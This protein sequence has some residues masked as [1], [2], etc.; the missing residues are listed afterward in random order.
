M[1]YVEEKLFRE[2]QK[3]NE[4]IQVR[5]RIIANF[6]GK[7]DS[8]NFAVKMYDELLS[9]ALNTHIES[10]A[11]A[12]GDKYHEIVSCM[13]INKEKEQQE[14]TLTIKLDSC[15]L[16]EFNMP[17]SERV[18]GRAILREEKRN[19]ELFYIYNDARP[20]TKQVIPAAK[21]FFSLYLKFNVDEHNFESYDEF[22]QAISW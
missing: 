18:F 2:L 13:T 7:L 21:E 6:A 4:S 12:Q 1:G 10:Y 20:I 11:T 16:R 8:S 5:N 3:L 15:T 19:L 22:L 14:L 17:Y 9:D